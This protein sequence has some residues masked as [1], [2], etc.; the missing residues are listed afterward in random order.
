MLAVFMIN[1]IGS[2]QSLKSPPLPK[3]EG[4]QYPNV[5]HFHP[6]SVD[7]KKRARI[8]L[9]EKIVSPRVR[10]W[11]ASDIITEAFM[12]KYNAILAR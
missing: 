6:R 5:A 7:L 10:A 4:R 1:L 3:V 12:K 8:E 11:R 9:K 2:M